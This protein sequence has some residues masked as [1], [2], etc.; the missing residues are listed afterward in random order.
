M[1][2]SDL[3]RL[4][5]Q[6]LDVLAVLPEAEEQ[7]D[8]NLLQGY[9]EL[10]AQTL[11]TVSNLNRVRPRRTILWNSELDVGAFLGRTLLLADHVL[12]PDSVFDQ[13]LR[14]ATK[15]DLRRAARRQL[16]HEP[17]I[18]MGTVVP[19][20]EGVA[21]ATQGKTALELTARDLQSRS[22]VD[23]VRRELVVEGPTA[24]EAL[25]IRARDDLSVTSD[26]FWLH[27][28][29]LRDSV[30]EDDR[31]FG[32]AMLQ[33]YDP[34]FDYG[35]WMKQVSDEAVSQYVQR[36]NERFVTAN[37]FGAEY[38][39]P[40]LFEARLLQRRPDPQTMTAPQAAMWAD[41]P[42]LVDLTSPDLAKLLRNEP[43]VQ[44]LRDEVRNSMAV[45]RSDADRIDALT[46]LAHNVNAASQRIVNAA[47][48]QRLWQ[49]VLP[50]GLGT[51]SM[52]VGGITGG[53]PALV[54]GGL[55]ILAGIAPYLGSH[56]QQR[57]AAAYLF[58]TAR[59]RS[60][61]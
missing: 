34:T 43:A 42:E 59:R 61:R 26:K 18:K 45:A 54:G 10:V 37:V 24:R 23:W 48:T 3:G 13:M 20:P 16:A 9:F 36:T 29:I 19:L 17:L 41:I 21:M 35:P 7:P 58:V 57:Q 22:L 46:Q 49:G 30:N 8:D 51:A 15:A 33:K 52:V 31:T 25:F 11:F 4:R 47:K 40:S 56:L 6:V 12:Y 1:G 27:G 5:V 32:T 55:S 60:R 38:V 53:V 44:D 39:S 2:I 14:G 28:R 50:T